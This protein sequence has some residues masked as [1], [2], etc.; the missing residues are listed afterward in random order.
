MNVQDF[1]GKHNGYARMKDLKKNGFHTRVI[2]KA[3]ND[4]II[5]KVKPGLYKLVD[6]EW[7][8]NSSFIDITKVSSKAVICLN[9]ALHY[10]NL[11]T[12]NP[13]LVHV[14]V[15]NN[16]ARFSLDYPPV[17]LFY[18]SD[19]IYPLEIIEIKGSNGTFKI[20]SIEKTICDAFRYRKRIGEDLALEALKNYM[21]RKESD[22]NRL[23][24]VAKECKIAKVIEPY[25]KAMVVE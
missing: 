25:I 2:A 11:S 1:F 7:D 14:A 17:K 15:P 16:T 20:Y 19:T 23:Y 12:I 9:S 22:L 13:N 18:F 24:K 6:Y 21:R 3:L 10:Y 8:E 5:E 4:N